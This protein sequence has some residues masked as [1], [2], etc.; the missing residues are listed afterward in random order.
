M[1]DWYRVGTVSVDNA[2]TAVTGTLTGWTSQVVAGDAITFD[3]GGKWYEIASVESNTA[4][5]LATAF[6]ETTVSGGAYAIQ[7]QARGHGQVSN[8]S[9]QVAALLAQIPALGGGGDGNKLIK[10][11]SGGTGFELS[12]F[13]LTLLAGTTLSGGVIREALTA[14][15]TYYVRSD[16]N[17]SNNGLTNVSGGAFAT[18][19]RAFDVIAALDIGTHDVTIQVGAG[20]YAGATL[21]GPWL[22]RGTV[23]VV[24]DTT[25]PS[26]CQFDTISIVD[27]GRLVV[28]GL[29]LVSSGWGFYLN[30]RASLVIN[31]TME[32]GACTAG[33]YIADGYSTISIDTINVFV[34]GSAGYHMF[35]LGGSKVRQALGSVTLTST[36]AFTAFVNVGSGSRGEFFSITFSGPEPTGLEYIATAY[37]VIDAYGAGAGYLPGSGGYTATGG[38]YL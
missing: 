37:G 1:S 6:A 26:N 10:A 33:H 4:L 20:T 12:S 25:T 28:G 14:N 27:G 35:V 8:L 16:G 19:Q 15:R 32:F 24:G 36:Y 23:T 30:N 7:R 2:S 38:L 18:L 31:G 13:A 11:N 17:D 34:T 22:G 5:T 29:K 3:G 21:S 9:A